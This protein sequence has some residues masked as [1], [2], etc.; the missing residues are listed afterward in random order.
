MTL[1]KSRVETL[2]EEQLLDLVDEL[3]L[4]Y[5]SLDESLHFVLLFRSEAGK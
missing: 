3:F 1:E 4:G 2:V 5:N